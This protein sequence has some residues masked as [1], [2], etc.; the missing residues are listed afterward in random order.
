VAYIFGQH[1][2]SERR[3][4]WIDEWS[5]QLPPQDL[6]FKSGCLPGAWDVRVCEP[7]VWQPVICGPVPPI[8]RPP[9]ASIQGQIRGE[10][11]PVGSLYAKVDPPDAIAGHI[12]G[13]VIPVGSLQGTFTLP[14][15]Q[16]TI[17]GSV[18][19]VGSLQGS[20][21][22]P[23]VQGTITGVTQPVGSLQGKVLG[24]GHFVGILPQFGPIHYPPLP[25]LRSVIRM[26]PKR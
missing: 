12:T 17:T 5:T 7:G 3:Y 8:D 26:I 6:W 16:G 13:S 25:C 18:I 4:S 2:Y 24:A 9:L 22:L 11:R 15:V 19:P 21:T 14:A 10:I 1:L 23:A 20:I